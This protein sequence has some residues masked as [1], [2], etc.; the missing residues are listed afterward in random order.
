M[1]RIDFPEPRTRDWQQ[2][3]NACDAARDR[4]VAA[5]EN[6]EE[7]TVKSLYKD[8]RMQLVYKSPDEPFFGKCAYCETMVVG[9]Q[10]GDIDHY[11]PKAAVSNELHSPVTITAP[12]GT[13]TDHPGYYWLAYDWQNLLLSCITCNQIKMSRVSR[14]LIGKGTRFP[15]DG[16]RALTMGH[17]TKENPLLL[18]PVCD[19]PADHMRVDETGVMI[20]KTPR[21]DMCIAVFGLN[22]RETLVNERARCVKHTRNLLALIVCFVASSADGQA[23]D[24]SELL[25][26]LRKIEDGR[27]QYSAA[28][29]AVIARFRDGLAHGS[30]GT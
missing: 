5:H 30:E 17:E 2:W 12:D 10:H 22:A 26:Q 4:L 29:R 14:R 16:F 27:V 6:D 20:G 3:R 9:F 15:V 24:L 28:G 19:D 13:E 11:R 7:P 18:H 23:D 25:L 21:G 1:I 8:Q